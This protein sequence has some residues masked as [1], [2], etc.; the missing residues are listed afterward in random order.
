GV[1]PDATKSQPAPLLRRT[2]TVNGPVQSARAYVTSHGLYEMH[3][4]GKRVG[5]QVFTPG[6]TSY[7]KR[8]QY[9]TYD[10]TALVQRGENAAGVILGEGWY[11]GF[12]GFSGQRNVYGNRGALLAQI[13]IVYQD[14]HRETIGTDEKWKCATGPILMSEIYM[15]ETYD[16]RL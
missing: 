1:E 8:L 6:W 15:G 7:K 13:E 12:I 5:D 10:V 16:A 14:G 9:Q 11:R 2:F 4:N 3:L